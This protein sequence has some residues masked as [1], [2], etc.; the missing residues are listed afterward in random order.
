MAW[1]EKNEDRP[2]GASAKGKDFLVD[3]S[4]VLMG[5]EYHV[6]CRCTRAFGGCLWAGRKERHCAQLVGMLARILCI[7]RDGACMLCIV[8]VFGELAKDCQ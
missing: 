2:G 1:Q 6:L 8:G 4:W 7:T 3:V 5:R